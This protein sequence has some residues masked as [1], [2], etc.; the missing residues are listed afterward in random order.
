MFRLIRN[1]FSLGAL[2]LVLAVTAAC[3]AATPNAPANNS[4]AATAVEVAPSSTTKVNLNTASGDDFLNAIPGL[5]NRMVR[6][7]QEYRPYLSIQQFRREIGKYVD[8]AQV[9]TY[10]QYVYVPINVNESDAAT[11]QQIPGLSEAEAGELIA[12]R[13]F[14]SNDAFLAKLTAYVSGAELTTAQ[15]Y[16]S[17]P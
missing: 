7:F 10:E 16:L 5:G 15:S 1:R 9:A 3:S 2:A 13:P 11:L 14:T 8:Q 4:G 12:A 17:A 6:E